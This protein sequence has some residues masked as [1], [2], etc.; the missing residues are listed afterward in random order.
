MSGKPPPPPIPYERLNEEVLP[1]HSS[2]LPV[3]RVSNI[4]KQPPLQPLKPPQSPNT[5]TPI[6]K[7]RPKPVSLPILD[8]KSDDTLVQPITVKNLRAVLEDKNKELPS[9][10]KPLIP[11]KRPG[12]NI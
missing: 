11:P 3:S 4:P 10:K 2:V 8:Q 9:V 1:S 5:S 6:P 12:S 7:S